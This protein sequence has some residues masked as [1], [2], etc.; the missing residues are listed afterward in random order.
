VYANEFHSNCNLEVF[1]KGV[2]GEPDRYLG[3]IREEGPYTVDVPVEKNWYVRPMGR[4]SDADFVKLARELKV[5]QV[6]GLSLSDR[7]D[8]SNK[9]LKTLLIGR[10]LH[11][12]LLADTRVDNAGLPALAALTHLEVLS[13]GRKVNDDKL[14]IIGR[15]RHL[16]GLDVSHCRITD[17]GLKTL[18]RLPHLAS[19]NLTGTRITDAGAKRSDDVVAAP[20]GYQRYGGDG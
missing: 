18:A 20:A 12:L 10:E 1:E 19:L 17:R 9:T 6:P 13:L 2:D 11:I 7:W 3:F 8:V 4:Y 15:L 14:A 5:T 16:T